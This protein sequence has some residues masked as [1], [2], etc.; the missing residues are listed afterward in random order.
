M[1]PDRNKCSPSVRLGKYLQRHLVFVLISI[2][3]CGLLLFPLAD[4]FDCEYAHP[5]G[6]DEAVYAARTAVFGCWLVGASLL[7]GFSRRRFGWTVPIAITLIACAT[8]P[9][10]G[11]AVQSW[12]NNEGPVMLIFGGSLG[13][14]SFC[15]G[16]IT[17]ALTDRLR[18][19][20]LRP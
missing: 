19:H 9:L 20:H 5:W 11:V 4:C 3:F 17:R 1:E 10:A 12:I 14:A 8:E 7:A 2:S 15:I 6:R 16:W 13:L 18:R